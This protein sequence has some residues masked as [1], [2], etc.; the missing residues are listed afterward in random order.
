MAS[1]SSMGDASPWR[2]A[3]LD[4]GATEGAHTDPG[5]RYKPTRMPVVR[6]LRALHYGHDHLHLLPELV[7]PA[8]RGEPEDR[9]VVGDVHPLCVRQ[10]VRGERGTEATDEAPPFTHAARLLR[11]WKERGVLVRDPRPSLYVYEQELDGSARRG[12]VALVRL[13]PLEGG[14]VRPHEL[15]VGR[16]TERLHAQLNATATQLSLVMAMVPDED[17]SLAG[18]LGQRRGRPGLRTDDG[19]GATNRVWRDGDPAAQLELLTALAE[20]PA[21]IADGHHRYAA[22][23]RYQQQTASGGRRRRERPADYLMMLLVPASDPGLRCEAA[24]RVCPK[25]PERAVALLGSLTDRFDVTPL[26]T[27]QALLDFLANDDGVRF[28][29]VRPGLR[30]G[31]RLRSDRDLVELLPE[32]LQRV[33]AAVAAE[34]ILGPLGESA[35]LCGASGSPWAHNR[36]SGRQVAASAFAGQVDLAL[37]LRPTPPTRV[38]EVALAGEL[39]PPKSTNFVP[40]PTKGLLMNSLL[41]F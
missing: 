29:L 8:V 25:L 36:T 41:T 17:G 13:T 3:P 35:R 21:V 31:L 16:S 37:L 39:M 33:D 11:G 26:A 24:H 38:L 34:L 6:P 14:L 30:R 27:E 20:Q 22:A 10:L 1:T 5:L 4:P 23:L 12:L 19:Q 28:G 9:T 7:S 32:P 15:M 2:G 18:Y 40:K